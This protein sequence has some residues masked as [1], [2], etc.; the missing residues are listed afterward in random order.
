MVITLLYLKNTKKILDL[1]KTINQMS[2]FF[3]KNL[4]SIFLDLK[5]IANFT[6]FTWGLLK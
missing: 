3:I 2:I 5:Q 4:C 6:N 1:Y